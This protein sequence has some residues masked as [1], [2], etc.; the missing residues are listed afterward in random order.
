[1]G[2][3]RPRPVDRL[4]DS[5]L[6]RA[7]G[8]PNHPGPAGRGRRRA[9]QG[10]GEA[11]KEEE[12]L[13]SERERKQPS[14]GSRAAGV[15]VDFALNGCGADQTGGQKVV[16]GSD[17]GTDR[18]APVWVTHA[19]DSGPGSLLPGPLDRILLRISTSDD[20]GTAIGLGWYGPSI[21]SIRA[22]IVVFHALDQMGGIWVSWA[23]SSKH[24]GVFF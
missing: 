17:L 2:A 9:S 3:R 1:M 4:A 15:A 20:V 5:Q 10:R 19:H 7:G 8:Q 22:R 11:R 18:V 13:A 6:G 21:R 14:H 16:F 24:S 23:L 12:A